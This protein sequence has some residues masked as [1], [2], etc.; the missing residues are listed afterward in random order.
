MC[1]GASLDPGVLGSQGL[2]QW[3]LGEGGG[4]GGQGGLRNHSFIIWTCLTLET[5]RAEDGKTQIHSDLQTQ[6]KYTFSCLLS[7]CDIA[8][9]DPLATFTDRSIHEHRSSK[10]RANIYMG[11]DKQHVKTMQLAGVHN[12]APMGSRALAAVERL[13]CRGAFHSLQMFMVGSKL[14][15]WLQSKKAQAIKSRWIASR[16]LKSSNENVEAA[17]IPAIAKSQP[18]L[19]HGG[20]TWHLFWPGR[21]SM[22]R[23]RESGSGG[24]HGGSLQPGGSEWRTDDEAPEEYE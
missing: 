12:S 11:E 10:H 23:L 24:Y 3:G 20:E 13:E 5:L 2:L 15:K 19:K 22:V 6:Q 8:A 16:A 14:D 18:L 4:G 7:V 9:I 21:V 1:S 17:P